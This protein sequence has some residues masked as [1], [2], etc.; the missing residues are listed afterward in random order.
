MHV[1]DAGP[2]DAPVTW[3]LL[4]DG[5]AWGFQFRH[6]MPALAAAGHRVVV[7]KLIGF[8]RS[9]KPKRAAAHSL[10][11][12]LQTLRELIDRLDLH[13]VV[14]AGCGWGG[15]LARLLPV[16]G[17]SEPGRYRALLLIDAEDNGAPTRALPTAPAYAAPFPDAGHRAALRAAPRLERESQALLDNARAFWGA[18]PRG[19]V[20]ATCELGSPAEARAL[21]AQALRH[22]A[23]ITPNPSL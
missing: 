21:A 8:G 19:L 5:A 15:R 23:F 20:S 10:A 14:L 16:S 7:P 9:D 11:W 12:H 3:L 18:A 1:I 13:R 6:L 22:F 17:S 4:H 2:N